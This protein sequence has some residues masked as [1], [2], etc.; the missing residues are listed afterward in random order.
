MFWGEKSDLGVKSGFVVGKM[1]SFLDESEIWVEKVSS[2][3][4]KR[5]PEGKKRSYF[6]EKSG[7]FERRDRSFGEEWYG[8][9]RKMVMSLG[10]KWY[11][12]RK[13][14]I[15]S[16]EM[17]HDARRKGPMFWRK[18]AFGRETVLFWRENLHVVE[19]KG[20]REGNVVFLE[21]KQ[22]CI[23]QARSHVLWRAVVFSGERVLFR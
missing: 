16:G 23:W 5:G 14:C 7:V 9:G 2:M 8:V 18:V 17:S 12:A 19:K 20:A 22:H 4:E 21:S 6:W 1:P 11:F 13:S 10:E 3:E 15:F